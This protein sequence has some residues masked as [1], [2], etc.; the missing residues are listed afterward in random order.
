MIVCKNCG[1]TF[2]EN[3]TKCPYCGTMHLAG[4]TA[5]Y[6]QKFEDMTDDLADLGDEHIDEYKKAMHTQSK[7]ALR[8]ISIVAAIVVGASAIIF[9]LSQV[10]TSA[11]QS[12]NVDSIK[13]QLAWQTETFPMLDA[14]YEAGDYEALVT[15]DSELYASGADYTIYEWAHYDFLYTYY[16][17]RTCH[18]IIESYAQGGTL[19]DY[20]YTQL[21][22]FSIAQYDDH[23][24]LNYTEEDTLLIAD[25][26]A[27]VTA[28]LDE[29]IGI[30]AADTLALY[31]EF[32][33]ED[34]WVSYSECA[35]Y[36]EAYLADIPT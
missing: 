34:G 4:A 26:Y 2:A 5:A 6:N 17:Y 28:F 9:A 25:F 31:E 10:V 30:S 11:T 33:Q 20:N 12:S 3:V 22:Y 19:S 27:E 1:G 23:Y 36:I 13:A 29:S 32:Y 35:D 21:F 18:E 8:Q 24:Y 7:H 16:S 14:L 15:F